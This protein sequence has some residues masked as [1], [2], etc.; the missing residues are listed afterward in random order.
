MDSVWC[1]RGKLY[2]NSNLH[3]PLPVTGAGS[4]RFGLSPSYV[5][6]LGATRREPNSVLYQLPSNLAVRRGRIRRLCGAPPNRGVN[7]HLVVHGRRRERWWWLRRCNQRHFDF[8]GG[9]SGCFLK[10]SGQ[11]NW[12]LHFVGMGQSYGRRTQHSGANQPCNR[13]NR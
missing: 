7:L 6:E 4:I 12:A 3:S 2:E 13:C 1:V 10:H 11:T 5:R 9:A 8:H